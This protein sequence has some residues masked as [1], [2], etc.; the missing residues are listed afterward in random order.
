MLLT[1]GRL[2][3]F[4]GGGGRSRALD[5]EPSFG[6]FGGLFDAP[7]YTVWNAGASW[8]LLRHLELFGRV[9]NVFDRRYE[10]VFGFPALGRAALA[11]FRV[12]TSR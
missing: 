5:V 2:T 11:G 1:S 3:G 7:G 4:I 9:N 8:K 12:A 10:E 6:T